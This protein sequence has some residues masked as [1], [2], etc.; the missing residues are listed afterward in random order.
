MAYIQ[1]TKCGALAASV[2]KKADLAQAFRP[3]AALGVIAPAVLAGI[4]RAVT[5]LLRECMAWWRDRQQPYAVCTACGH[6]WKIG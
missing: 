1:C 2:Y 6:L 5:E 4:I 3:D